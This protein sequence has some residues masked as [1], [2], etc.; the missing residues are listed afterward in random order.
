MPKSIIAQSFGYHS[1]RAW[2][3]NPICCWPTSFLLNDNFEYHRSDS[4]RYLL[5]PTTAQCSPIQQLLYLYPHLFA[6]YF[7]ILITP[8][9]PSKRG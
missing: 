2:F 7:S 9:L 8:S 3:R 6:P 5:Q 1:A 4:G